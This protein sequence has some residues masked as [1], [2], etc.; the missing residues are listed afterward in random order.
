MEAA[1]LN[2]TTMN[3][4]IESI[5]E[6]LDFYKNEVIRFEAHLK[7]IVKN[8]QHEFPVKFECKEYLLNQYNKVSS[9]GKIISNFMRAVNELITYYVIKL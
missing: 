2:K 3:K 7:E 5:R 9:S 6:R 8:C 1:I 4:Y